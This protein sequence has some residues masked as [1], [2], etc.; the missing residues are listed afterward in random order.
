MLPRNVQYSLELLP[1]LTETVAEASLTKSA[2]Y[3]QCCFGNV[4]EKMYLVCAKYV[5][6]LL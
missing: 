3:Q 4:T 6:L 5:C 1:I 2:S